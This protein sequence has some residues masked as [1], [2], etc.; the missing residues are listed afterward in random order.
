MVRILGIDPGSR[1]TGFGII[2]RQQ[3]R[4]TYVTCGCIQIQADSMPLRLQEIYVGVSDIIAEYQP[5]I[6]AIEQVFMYRNA[7]SALKLGQAR[8]VAIVA[9]VQQGLT[10][11]EYSPNQ[12]KQAVVGQGHAQKEQVQQMVKVLLSL[13]A[14]PSADAAD[15]LAGALCHAYVSQS[16]QQLSKLAS[17]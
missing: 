10:V 12:I 17:H 4:V 1:I 7:A 3:Q 13:S 2:E 9:A 15:A 8:G 14:L 6:L 16:A 5:T 11:Y